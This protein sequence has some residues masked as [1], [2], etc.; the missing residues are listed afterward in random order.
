MGGQV[1]LELMMRFP[2]KFGAFCGVQIAI[3]K[4]D[5]NRYAW[6]L[7]RAFKKKLDDG[8]TGRPIRVVTATRDTYRWSNVAFCR[9]LERKHLDASLQLRQGVHSSEWMRKAGCFESLLWL[10]QT[11]NGSF[12]AAPDAGDGSGA[13]AP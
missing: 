12:N 6:Q 9:A 2:E 8:D 1:G 13:E 4:K 10:D 5:A 7:E 11:L 3:K